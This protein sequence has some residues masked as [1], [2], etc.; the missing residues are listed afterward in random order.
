MLIGKKKIDLKRGVGLY[1]SNN[2]P[3]AFL[4]IMPL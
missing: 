3:I 2:H 4:Q 1:Y